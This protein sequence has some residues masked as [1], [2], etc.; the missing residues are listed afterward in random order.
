MSNYITEITEKESEEKSVY[1]AECDT[2]VKPVQGQV[3]VLLHRLKKVSGILSLVGD[4]SESNS[5]FLRR[6]MGHVKAKVVTKGSVAFNGWHP[7]E[8]PQEGQDVLLS[9]N[10]CGRYISFDG[11]SYRVV[12]ENDILGIINNQEGLDDDSI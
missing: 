1:Y 9:G 8:T 11:R 6:Q 10:Y 5:N 4:D 2:P 3:L 7:D 12:D